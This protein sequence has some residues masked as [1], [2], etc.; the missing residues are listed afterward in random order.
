MKPGPA[1]AGPGFCF[2]R[3]SFATKPAEFLSPSP[4]SVL[5]KNAFVPAYGKRTMAKRPQ[6]DF[7]FEPALDE[8]LDD[9]VVQAVMDRD[10]VAREDILDLAASVQE[11][12]SVADACL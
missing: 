5:G 6:A 4:A 2:F 3:H 7:T 10:G 12:F 8:V 9:P 11:R 1:A